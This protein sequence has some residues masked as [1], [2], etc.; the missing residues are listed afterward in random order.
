MTVEMKQI[1]IAIDIRE[2]PRPDLG[3]NID[4]FPI[5]R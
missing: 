1:G 2:F 3:P 4:P 5:Q